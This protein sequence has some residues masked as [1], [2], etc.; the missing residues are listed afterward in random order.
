V[1]KCEA[2][3]EGTFQKSNLRFYLK[4]ASGGGK[5]SRE[6]MDHVQARV[7]S[8]WRVHKDPDDD[9]P[10]GG[11]SNRSRAVDRSDR[12]GSSLRT[13]LQGEHDDEVQSVHSETSSKFSANPQVGHWSPPK[14]PFAGP[15]SPLN[16]PAIPPGAFVVPA[17]A[18]VVMPAGTQVQ[19]MAANSTPEATGTTPPGSEGEPAA[20]PEDER[21]QARGPVSY[22][23]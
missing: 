8:L 21:A 2:E 20:E 18:M 16:G 10:G 1:A 9:E 6:Q 22:A 4:S 14:G 12:R 5:L 11:A 17:G 3:S 19:Y 13:Y 23:L 7:R 15:G